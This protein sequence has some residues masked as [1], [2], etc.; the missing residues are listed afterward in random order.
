MS[1]KVGMGIGV[2]GREGG[3]TEIINKVWIVETFKTVC[4][5]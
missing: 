3:R 1:W 5:V 2:V 4:N